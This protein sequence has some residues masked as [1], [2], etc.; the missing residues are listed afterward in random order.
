MLAVWLVPVAVCALLV[1]GTYGDI[2]WFFSKMAVVTVGG[3]YAVLAYVAQD[4]VQAY[5]WLGPDEMLAGLGLAETTPGPLILVLQ[6]VGFL[7]GFRAPDG[8]SGVAGGVVASVLTLW[9]TFAPCFVFVF[10]GAPLIERLQA[11][12]R[13][14]GALAAIT[15]SVVGVVA[16]LAVWF[17]LQV[18]FRSHTPF[19][20]GPVA[21][22]VPVPGSIDL[23]AL[24]LAVLAAVSLFRFR[25][26]VIRT[27]GITAGAGLVIR[28]VLPA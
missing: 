4:A 7:A 18:L 23:A 16:N 8:L 2:A 5:Q 3:A 12:R 6:F 1:G 10:L 13:L 17:A 11:N 25:L 9:V 14:S 22:E 27:L 28:L 20:A 26:G 15:A 21:F 19:K 24:G